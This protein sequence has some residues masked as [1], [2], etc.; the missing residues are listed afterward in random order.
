MSKPVVA[1]IGANGVVG[2]AVLST[3]VSPEYKD[4]ISFPV[5]IITRSE[6]KTKQKNAV[7]AE[8]PTLFKFHTNTN[9]ITGENLSEA[10]KGVNVVINTTPPE[11][12]QDKIADAVAENKDTVKL[13]IVSDFGSDTTGNALGPFEFFGAL[14]AH[15]REYARGLGIKTV[16]FYNGLFSEFALAV[17][18]LGGIISNTQGFYIT[19]DSDYATTSI[20]DVAHS[21]VAFIVNAL[22]ESDLSKV[23]DDIHIRGDIINNKKVIKVYEEVT[24]NKLE[25]SEV[26][27]DAAVADAEKVKA[28]GIRSMDDALAI[29]KVIFSQGYGGINPTAEWPGKSEVQFETIEQVAKR[30]YK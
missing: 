5:H 17:P 19:P 10:L 27:G 20:K 8:N 22:K 29:L 7:V 24:G 25:V 18:G 2:P 21:V 4:K 11:F 30:L 15:T 16:A 12:N 1:V 6:E 23:P 14:K 28:Q 26:P 13:Y 9:I 3:L